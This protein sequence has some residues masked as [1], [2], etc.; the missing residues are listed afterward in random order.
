MPRRQ[1]SS[2]MRLRE[3]ISLICTPWRTGTDW[4]S[5]ARNGGYRASRASPLVTFRDNIPAQITVHWTPCGLIFG[6]RYGGGPATVAGPRG[7]VRPYWS[8]ARPGIFGGGVNDAGRADRIS[9]VGQY[10]AHFRPGSTGIG[11]GRCSRR[12]RVSA[13][14]QARALAVAGV[15]CCVT[16]NTRRSSRPENA[17][18]C[19]RFAW[20]GLPAGTGR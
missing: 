12:L 4:T 19:G 2:T 7:A 1:P 3:Q 17:P 11:C 10:P 9:K 8:R 20:A 14:R 13:G 15:R 5:A 18:R 16:E 6:W